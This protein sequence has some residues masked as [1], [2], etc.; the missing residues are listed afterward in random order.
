MKESAQ[1]ALSFLRSRAAEFGFDPEIL[2]K[3]EI[4]VHIPAGAVPKDGPS[5]GITL[6]CSMLSAI[7]G[8]A[9]SGKIAM[10]GEI[11]LHGL[12]L[13]IGGLR[14][15]VLAALREDVAHVLVP[16]K[17]KANF[18]ML[19]AN[20]RKKIKV[21]F[22]KSYADVFDVMFGADVSDRKEIIPI[23]SRKVESSENDLAS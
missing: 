4:H 1:T 18:E 16:F 8:R 5:A 13:P 10:T 21:T 15:K 20:I 7:L 17:N 12:V 6:A 2:N 14:E 11:T 19:P 22:V 3:N 9:P 23:R